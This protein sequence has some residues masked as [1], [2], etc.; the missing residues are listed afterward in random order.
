MLNVTKLMEDLAGDRPVFHS[1]AD[2]QHALAWR[3]HAEG[4]DAGIRLEWPVEPPDQ[5][6]R[7]YVDLWL[8]STNVAVELKYLTRGL[9]VSQKGERFA[10]RDQGAQDTRRYDFLKD[11][12]RLEQLSLSERTD[13]RAGFAILLTN[14]PLYWKPPGREGTNDAE[15]RIHDRRTIKGEMKWAPEASPGTKRGREGSICL[16][17]SYPLQWQDYG[18]GGHGK[19]QQFRYLAIQVGSASMLDGLR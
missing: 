1:E 4:L 10:L 15:F 3:I 17:G 19:Y 7:I 2:F 13:V 14:D 18:I 8:P 16:K 12:E 9:I 11:I 6:K 5:E